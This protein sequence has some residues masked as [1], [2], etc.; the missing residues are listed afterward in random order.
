MEAEMIL[1][2]VRV[3][4]SWLIIDVNWLT[5]TLNVWD[6]YWKIC[7]IICNTQKQQPQS[8]SLYYFKKYKENNGNYTTTNVIH[9]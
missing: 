5:N 9:T 7:N 2:N 3:S 8:D 6:S 4:S 1:G